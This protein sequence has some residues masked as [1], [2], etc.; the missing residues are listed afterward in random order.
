MVENNGIII[1]SIGIIHNTAAIFLLVLRSNLIINTSQKYYYPR[2]GLSL[3]AI[4]IN[5]MSIAIHIIV[6]PASRNYRQRQFRESE[7]QY[8]RLPGKRA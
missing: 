8:G 4:E 2:K 7:Q 1:A 5:Y 3:Y 6:Y